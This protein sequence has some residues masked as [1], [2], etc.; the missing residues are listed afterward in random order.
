MWKLLL[1]GYGI[2][3][4]LCLLILLAEEVNKGFHIPFNELFALSVL[5]GSYGTLLGMV[6]CA[7]L[8]LAPAEAQDLRVIPYPPGLNTTAEGA[9]SAPSSARR[10][11]TW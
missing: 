5:G 3:S 11:F 1:M 8:C 2:V 7:S 6:A 9:S 10:P 4:L